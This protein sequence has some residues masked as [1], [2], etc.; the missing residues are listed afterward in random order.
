MSKYNVPLPY[1]IWSKPAAAVFITCAYYISSCNPGAWRGF[2][3]P[4]YNT[5]FGLLLLEP[6]GAMY[7][8]C[9]TEYPDYGPDDGLVQITYLQEDA[10]WRFEA[11]QDWGA[12]WSFAENCTTDFRKEIKNF[13]YSVGYCDLERAESYATEW[14]AHCITLY[15]EYRNGSD[16]I[17]VKKKWTARNGMLTE[18]ET[19]DNMDIIYSYSQGYIYK[20]KI[21]LY[22][23][24]YGWR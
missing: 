19:K 17:G 15:D 4:D 12:F 1:R 21:W 7:N 8:W 18:Q 5:G 9:L 6:G 3:E 24:H 16:K 20:S 2:A 11:D 10:P 14:S 13:L 23:K 22:F